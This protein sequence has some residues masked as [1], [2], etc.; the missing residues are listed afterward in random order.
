MKQKLR[1]FLTLLL[2]AVASVGW[3]DTTYKLQ[4]VTSVE[5]GGLYVFEQGGYVM[6]N[7]CESSA[8]QTTNEF[9]TT[10][11]TGTETYVWALEE[12]ES[13]FNMLNISE[14]K[15]LYYGTSGTSVSLS[16]NTR[17][18]VFTFDLEGYA[19]IQVGST[20]GRFLGYTSSDSHAYKA[21]ATSNLSSY[22]HAIV[23]Y[24]L[25]KE[26]GETPSLK[27]NDLT[28]SSA[29]LTFDLY[30]SSN[31]QTVNFTTSSTGAISVSESEYVTTVVSGNTI[32]VTPVK[33][34]PTTQT[35]TVSQAADDT[36]AEGSAT[37]TVSITDNTPSTGTDVTFLA[38]TDIGTTTSNNS[39][40]EVT[41]DGVTMSSTDAAFATAQYRLYANSTTSFSTTSGKITK[42]VFTRNGSYNLSNLSTSSNIGEY[43]S[44]TGIWIGS[45]QSVAFSASAQVRLDKVVVTVEDDGTIAPPLITGITPFYESTEVTITAGDGA[46]IYYTTDGSN[47][48]T[49]STLYTAPFTIGATA[50]VKAIAV[51]DS[52]ESDVAEQEFR[53][54]A[55]MTVTEAIAYIETL[56]TET[57]AEDVYVSGIVSTV[58]SYSNGT[59]TYWISDDG[60]TINQMEVYRGKGLNGES[61]SAE[62][63]L[64]PGDE[65]VV[66]GKVKKYN[67]T[68]EFDSNSKLVNLV[69]HRKQSTGLNYATTKVTKYVGDANFTNELTNPNN[70]A[71]TYDSSDKT[72][73]TVA[74]NG[75]VTILAAGNTTITARYPGDE[76]YLDGSAS[77]TLEVKA[78]FAVEDG[79]FNFVEAADASYDYGSGVELTTTSSHYEE[80]ASTWTAVNVSLVAG[81]NYR[82]WGNDGT[83]RFQKGNGTMTISVPEG[84]VITSIVVTGGTDWTTV[85]GT[86]S[87]GTWTGSAQNVVFTA[88][89]SNG[90]N[91]SK[92]VVSYGE[93]VK[94]GSAGYTTYV[95]KNNVAIPEG[96]EVYIVTAINESSIHMDRVTGAIPA[97]TP[98]V[99]KA[100]EGTHGLP[101]AESA[102]AVSGNL[103]LASDGT[104]TG[105]GSIY[106]LGVGKEGDAKDKVGFYR[107]KSGAKVPDRK[108]YL[109]IPA[110]VS[111]RDFIGFDDETD[112]IRQIENGQ[113]TIE[114]AEIYNL[115]GQRVNK[116]QKGIY[117][118]NGKK[119]VVK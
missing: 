86:Y 57:S 53:K 41:K 10:G 67:T 17:A 109:V 116:A 111:V 54:T 89:T 30:N 98:V 85:A 75:E 61:F 7:T 4:Q 22:P 5:A 51:I 37:F 102:T 21:Y 84:K 9:N 42:I 62:D 73:A 46:T 88:G 68:P 91:I 64:Q 60:S 25:V 55:V 52:K 83:L 81:G 100:S 96:I 107:V 34:T 20:T 18:W 80:A 49:S 27:D 48:T 3:G 74:D 11:L 82:W 47:P 76:T 117:I 8:L 14:E 113:L 92:I 19:L 33:V 99:V 104:V 105:D 108:A 58:D 63:D 15:Y 6:N 70:L 115:S 43:N 94:V 101:I 23:V 2:C 90:N 69:L 28:L 56:G 110:S 40:D 26:S 39:P 13:G 114:N 12:N 87:N 38:G 65:V 50:T 66:C 95:T 24:Q 112:G 79:V 93:P 1:V 16:K 103:L 36:Y 72:V 71:V 29:S 31:A 32:T 106:A 97:N 44:S 45:A 77:Y 35:I 119:V 78:P 59:I 118:V